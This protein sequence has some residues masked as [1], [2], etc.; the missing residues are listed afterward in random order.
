MDDKRRDPR[1]ES[2]QKQGCEGRDLNSETLARDMS[3]GAMAI[4]VEKPS[5]VSAEDKNKKN[6]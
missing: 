4:T 6:K 3:R 2:D 1:F 5:E